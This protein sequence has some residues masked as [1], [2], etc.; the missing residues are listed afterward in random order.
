MEKKQK[1]YNSIDWGIVTKKTEKARSDGIKFLK[2]TGFESMNFVSYNCNEF[3]NNLDEIDKMLKST[4]SGYIAIFDPINPEIKRCSI[5]G[6]ATCIKHVLEFIKINNLNLYDF[7]I[8]FTERILDVEDSFCGVVMTD[9]KGNTVI[10]IYV[11][12]SN[13]VGLTSAG[14]DPEKTQYYRFYDFGNAPG[15]KQIINK[16]KTNCEAF[17][18]YYEFIYG[19]VNGKAKV[20]FTSYSDN[21]QYLNI[22]KNNQSSNNGKSILKF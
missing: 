18:G 17:S 9:G 19:K 21:P 3:L 10:E 1:Y 4:K 13:I 14:V 15:V 16:I 22:L 5:P 11:D 20:Y 2:E 6:D 8:S 12:S 7:K